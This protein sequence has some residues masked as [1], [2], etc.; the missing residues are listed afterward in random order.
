MDWR[1]SHLQLY[2]KR[3]RQQLDACGNYPV[4]VDVAIVV[5]GNHIAG[6]EEGWKLA[7]ADDDPQS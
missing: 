4:L 2:M 7:A 6:G 3:L 5:I 1:R